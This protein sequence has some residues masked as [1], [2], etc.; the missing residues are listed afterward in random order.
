M[1]PE[2]EAIFERAQLL[3]RESQA[4]RFVFRCV[5]LAASPNALHAC[6]LNC[7]LFSLARVHC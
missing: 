3:K 5:S 7:R 2:E 4:V 6:V 1:T